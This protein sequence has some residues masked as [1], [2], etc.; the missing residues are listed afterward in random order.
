MTEKPVFRWAQ[1]EDIPELTALWK[2]VFGDGEEFI[3]PFYET[4]FKEKRIPAVFEQ[5][6]AVCACALIDCE[7]YAPDGVHPVVYLYALCTSPDRRGRGYGT[8]LMDFVA[9][10]AEAGGYEGVMLH[11]AT[12]SLWEYY[13]KRGFALAADRPAFTKSLLAEQG[14]ELASDPKTDAMSFDMLRKLLKTQRLKDD[15]AF[16]E[17]E[18]MQ[19]LGIRMMEY[20]GFQ[21]T[22]VNKQGVFAGC[23]LAKG[24]EKGDEVRA[25][26]LIDGHQ[27]PQGK[28]DECGMFISCSPKLRLP[29]G[30]RMEMDF[31][32]E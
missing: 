16:V 6:R 5:G 8:A 3:L 18:K 21:I 23:C 12:E 25:L 14:Y 24:K 2:Q 27:R 19:E 29:A 13:R 7:I 1:R 28:N 31:T 17:G 9:D 32:L 26:W 20:A 15:W 22:A 10:E 30:L 11:P 4:F